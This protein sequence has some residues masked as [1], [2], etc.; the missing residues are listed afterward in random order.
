MDDFR[1][2]RAHVLG[3]CIAGILAAASAAA[4]DAAPST[5]VAQL[6]PADDATTAPVEASALEEVVV[7]GSRLRRPEYDSAS[8]MLVVT[9]E[10]T[11]LAGFSSLSE[12]L[13]SGSITSGASQINNAYGG[14]VTDG[15]PGANTIGL[16]GLGP[17]RTLVLLNGRRL[18]PAGTRGSV[19]SADL[20]V[21]PTA[22]IE[23]IDVL[24]DGA[25]SI[26]GSDAVA[27]VVNIITVKDPEETTVEAQFNQTEAGGGGQSRFS[28]ASGTSGE[29]YSLGG[30]L[31]YYKRQDLTLGDRDWTRCNADYYY[32]EDGTR[33]D[34]IDPLT[35][36]YKC[37]PISETGSNGSTINTL[38]TLAMDGVPGLGTTGT[39]FTR[40]RP[41]SAVTEGLI[42]FEGVSLDSRDTFDPRMLD[43]SLISPAEVFTAYG[44]GRYQLE[45][46]GDAELYGEVLV[47]RRESEQTGYRQLALDYWVGSPLLPSTLT[48]AGKVAS[49]EIAPDGYSARA[50]IGFGNDHS[51]QTV[52]FYKATVGIRGDLEFLDGWR[53]DAYASYSKSDA[54]YTFQAFLIDRMKN[55]LDVVAATPQTPAGLVRN[56]LTCRVNLTNPNA[57]CIP[58]PALSAAVIGGALPQDW[59]GT[60]W[61]NVTG[62]TTYDETV[63]SAT[64]D[65]ALFDLPAGPVSAALGLEFRDA[66]IDDTPALDSQN[67][68]LYNF[69]TSTPT[70]GSDSVWEVYAETELPLLRD[71][72]MVRDLSLNL[73]ARYTEYDSYGDD[74]TYK[75][76]L[77]YAM[78]NWLSMRATY[79]TSY[80]APALFEQF[81][82][83]TTGFQSNT[84][85][86]CNDYGSKNPNSARYQNCASEGLDPNFQANTSVEV[87]TLGGANAGLEAETSDNFTAGII[88]QPRLPGDWGSIGLA[89]DYYDIQIDN[90][91]TQAGAREILNRC[92]DD[93]NFRSGGGYCRLIDPRGDGNK[94]TVY[95]SYINLASETVRGVDWNARYDVTVGPGDLLV[96]LRVSQFLEQNNRLFA[97]DAWEKLNGTIEY[98][99][100]SGQ[101]DLDY[102]VGVWTARWSTEWI[103]EMDSY[104]YIFEDKE[105]NQ[106]N[107]G[108]DFDVPNYFVHDLSVQY[109]NESNW[110]ITTGI[111]NVG[112][113]TPPIISTGYYN[114]VGSSPLYSAY[115]YV[116]RQYFL[117]VKYAF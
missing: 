15:G 64:I 7:T 56:G 9:R 3:A 18:A 22:M 102:R 20:N 55:S 60:V 84:L 82:G 58:A 94:L 110:V 105:A 103:G 16:R 112:D 46:L 42:G 109:E 108:Y 49:S 86:P 1:L 81:Q 85:D 93:V 76:A 4:Q 113:K 19:G 36:K 79:G 11:T 53:Y 75:V 37:Y 50:F 92:Y 97:D 100:W 101:I 67:S 39:R 63:V 25:S 54:E 74:T 117:N 38:G 31:E 52:D 30:S 115:D 35:G 111:R 78:T 33:A 10:E 27:G 61:K 65:G 88:F 13:Q 51:E 14:Y 59:L 12:S 62:T 28:I 98:P 34:Y 66:S 90:G 68:N 47:N 114:R 73:S 106:E 96:N 72:P 71:M 41:N 44:E 83:A 95:D 91:V 21:L 80:R 26:Y 48:S 69:T 6:V 77:K 8:P 17:S 2:R 87:V 43:E 116:G 45:A 40:W 23:R 99:E 104:E 70:R 57:A 89:V 29:R 32:N 24:R 107:T 5:P